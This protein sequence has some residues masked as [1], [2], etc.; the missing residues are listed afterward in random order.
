MYVVELTYVKPLDA[1]ELQLEAHRRFLDEHYAREIFFASGPKNPRDG[2]V[3][4]VSGRV[5]RSELDAIL[6]HDPFRQHGLASYH[7]I[8][9]SAV[10]FHPTLAG[11]LQSCP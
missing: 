10:K 8:D 1:V 9:F 3:I 6:E 4:L 2:G 11:I 5:S 7:V